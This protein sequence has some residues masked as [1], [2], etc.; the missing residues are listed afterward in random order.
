[1][2]EPDV[3]YRIRPARP[4]EIGRL[5]EIEDE[6]G[7]MFGGLGLIDEARD[8]SFPW[9]ELRRLVD[10]EQVWVAVDAADRPVGMVIASVR[11]HVAYVEE[12]DVLPEHGRRGLG[13]RLLAR[14]ADWAQERGYVAVTL[15]T[16]RDV[17][18]NGPFYRRHGFRDLCPDE[19]SPGMGAIRDAEAR[20]GLRVDARVFMRCDL[21]R[22]DSCGLEVRVARQTRRIAEVVAFYR[23]GLGLPEID[24]FH[25]HAGYDGVMLGL[26]GTGTHLEFTAAEHLEPPSA[27]PESLLVLYLGDRTAVDRTIGRLAADPVPSAN[28]Y[29]DEVGVTVADPDGFRVVLVAD[30]W[31]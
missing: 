20:H 8:V 31:R 25:D 15:S 1:M 29:W 12:M 27:H 3:Q 5:R 11:D 17:P 30:S 22:V 9:E 10:D 7:T 28:P 16:F 21:P 2:A 18:W 24:R 14:V 4:A 23:D 19:W 26:P 13:S 6:A